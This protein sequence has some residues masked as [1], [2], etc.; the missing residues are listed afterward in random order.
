MSLENITAK[1]VAEANE[2]A[3]SVIAEAEAE[4]KSI[5]EEYE[6]I[7]EKESSQI[8]DAAYEKA[9]EIMHRANTQSLKEKRISILSTKWE[10][11][12]NTFLSA[13]KLLCKMPD[14]EQV[15]LMAGLVR[16]YQ[17]SDAELVFNKADRDRLG[18]AVVN[19]VNASAG[20]KGF[21]A[22]LS[23]GTGD[24]AGGLI[25][26]EGGVEANLSYEALVMSRREQLEDDVS[27]VLFDSE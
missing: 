14:D 4:A 19:S 16:K 9:S 25:L 23:A 3:A 26:K 13:V 5:A 15:V 1:I 12:D 21:K 18:K 17:R 22:K 27:S 2:F 20:A 8:I 11:L 24:F 10:Y 7:A 6:T